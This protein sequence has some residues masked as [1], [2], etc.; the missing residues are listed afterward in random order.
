M[1]N[2][3]NYN[4]LTYDKGN[5]NFLEGHKRKNPNF[6]FFILKNSLLMGLGIVIGWLLFV[7]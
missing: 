5:Q 4:G 1:K 2:H 7:Y 6:I 3:G